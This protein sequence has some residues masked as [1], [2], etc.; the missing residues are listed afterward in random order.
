MP[1]QVLADLRADTS[2]LASGS[3]DIHMLIGVNDGSDSDSSGEE[4]SINIQKRR[5]A[6]SVA[7]SDPKELATRLTSASFKPST[8]AV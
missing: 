1:A 6:E 5:P 2:A 4:F 7:W 3:T 8:V